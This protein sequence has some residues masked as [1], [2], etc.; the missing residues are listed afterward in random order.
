MTAKCCSNRCCSS[1]YKRFL[2]EKIT[3][4][5]TSTSNSVY[6]IYKKIDESCGKHEN[7]KDHSFIDS[8]QRDSLWIG[9]KE[10]WEDMFSIKNSS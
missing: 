8:L 3:F 5:E 10:N 1:K 7:M 4:L 2:P 9:K 6:D